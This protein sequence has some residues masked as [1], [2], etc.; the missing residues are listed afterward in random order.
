[1]SARIG[2]LIT[3]I[4]LVG[5]VACGDSEQPGLT[6]AVP[7]PQPCIGSIPGFG[8]FSDWITE[9]DI[10]NDAPV[11]TLLCPD[12]DVGSCIETTTQ[13]S[14]ITGGTYGFD[15]D[16]DG[17]FDEILTAEVELHSAVTDPGDGTFQYSWTVRNLGSG[18][19][20][21]VG[22]CVPI[23]PDIPITEENPL[24]GT[25][26]EDRL[27]GTGDDLGSGE[28]HTSTLGEII[29]ASKVLCP[30][31]LNPST[32]PVLELLFPLPDSPTS[33][34]QCKNGGW[35]FFGFADQ[36]QCIRFVETGKDSRIGE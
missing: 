2:R 17:E 24:L 1:M 21:G 15:A 28:V 19:V 34:E 7:R 3:A 33:K 23:G 32:D 5:T 13:R 18:A 14:G 11:T 16:R 20:T 25:A 29:E 36:G 4:L 10:F 6:E 9:P 31:H 26:G 22:K 30:L 27:S 35:E 8:G 12:D